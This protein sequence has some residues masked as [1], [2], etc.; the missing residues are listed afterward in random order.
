MIN[1]SCAV[2]HTVEPVVWVVSLQPSEVVELTSATF[3]AVPLML[4]GLL[5][6]SGE[7]VASAADDIKRQAS[8]ILRGM[9]CALSMRVS[10]R[11]K[12]QLTDAPGLRRRAARPVGWIAVEDL[13]NTAETRLLQVRFQRPQ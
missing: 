12:R 2:V 8:A 13:G 11:D 4:I 6:R 10:G 1:A 7:G 9:G 3:P 5:A